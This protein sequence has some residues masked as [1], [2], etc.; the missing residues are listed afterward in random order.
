MIVTIN[1]KHIQKMHV[2]INQFFHLVKSSHTAFVS[3]NAQQYRK[4]KWMKE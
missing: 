1:S 2:N 3:I 4:R